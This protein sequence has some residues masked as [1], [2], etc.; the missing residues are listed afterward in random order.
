MGLDPKSVQI[1]QSVKG[2]AAG[3]AFW[4]GGEADEGRVPARAA[5]P[6]HHPV[7]SDQPALRAKIDAAEVIVQIAAPPF[8]EQRFTI[9]A[10]VAERAAVVRLNHYPA[11]LNLHLEEWAPHR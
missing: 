10:S 7:I 1:V 11:A 5:T 9:F 2:D 6:C 8:A 3:E 4:C